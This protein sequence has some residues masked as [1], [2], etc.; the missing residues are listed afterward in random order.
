MV[1]LAFFFIERFE[2]DLDCSGPGPRAVPAAFHSRGSVSSGSSRTTPRRNPH[3]R[4]GTNVVTAPRQR[5]WVSL[6]L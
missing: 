4:T 2:T 5:W 1:F 3:Y 6:V